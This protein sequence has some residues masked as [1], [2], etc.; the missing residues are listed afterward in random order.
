MPQDIVL[1]KG[2]Y[3]KTATLSEAVFMITGVTIGAGIL[4]LPYAISRV[5]LGIG[6]VSI[7]GLGVIMLLLNLML[8]E[9]V[10]KTK[11]PLQI[12]GLARKYLGQWAEYLLLFL[13]VSGSYG[14][15]LAYMIGEG[16]TIS[17][18]LGGSPLWWS[19]M[20][21]I[22]VGTVVWK[23]LEAA[24][25]TQKIIGAAVI[26]L[27]IILSFFIV[28]RG[29]V[30]NISYSNWSQLFF[31]FGVIL[32]ALHGAPAVAEAEALLPG[33]PKKFRQALII[34]TL[35]PIAVYVLFSAAVVSVTG[36]HTTEVATLGLGK[37][38]GRGVVVGSS[39]FAMLA[40]GTAFVGLGIALKQT[41]TWDLKF[42]QW[43][44]TLLTLGVPLILF[45]AGMRSF[46]A[47]LNIVGGVFISLEAIL[48]IAIYWK[49]RQKVH[50]CPEGFCFHHVWLAVIPV[51][52][53]FAF[54][55]VWSIIKWIR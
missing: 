4:G 7:V 50:T 29:T 25:R 42:P 37:V 28:P 33:Q 34:G 22:V 31:P 23:G 41:F 48:A 39:V 14:S 44:A 10:A 52:A 5:G 35:I 38:F 36:L 18:L 27:I 2:V 32:F 55:G 26:G 17:Q 20:F 30:A 51:L 13:I 8:G 11:E 54:M 19:V 21:W 53:V 47:I 43:L 46:I 9:V 40:M 15:L 12:P 45:L 49:A 6:I 16:E 1:H 3:K 24:K